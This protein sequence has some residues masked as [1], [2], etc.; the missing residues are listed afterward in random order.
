MGVLFQDGALLGALS[1]VQNVTLPLTE[2]L[3]LSKELVREAGLEGTAH[4]GA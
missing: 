3:N 1:L 2:H 4:G